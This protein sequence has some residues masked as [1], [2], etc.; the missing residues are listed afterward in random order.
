MAGRGHT[1]I[2]II[3]IPVARQGYHKISLTHTL[4]NRSPPPVHFHFSY[5]EKN[6]KPS[7][8]G[9]KSCFVSTPRQPDCDN[10]DQVHVRTSVGRN[11]VL[12][13]DSDT[14][15]KCS[16]CFR[17]DWYARWSTNDYGSSVDLTRGDTND[18]QH[19]NGD[20]T[21]AYFYPSC[22]FCPH[23]LTLFSISCPS[24]AK[25]INSHY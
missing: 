3:L 13:L 23:N 16:I 9:L 19:S 10:L 20:T 2:Y 12:R 22:Y 8:L 18:E 11:I 24:F 7:G 25:S 15:N 17:L 21:Q 4:S 1:K 14:N 5:S 6:M